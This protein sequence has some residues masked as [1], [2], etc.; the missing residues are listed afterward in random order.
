[1]AVLSANLVN[2]LA[3]PFRSLERER[4]RERG[5]DAIHVH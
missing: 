1:V 2:P 3:S 4:E 5:G